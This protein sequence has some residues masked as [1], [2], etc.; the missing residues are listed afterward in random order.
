MQKLK[1]KQNAVDLYDWVLDENLK[2]FFEKCAW[3]EIYNHTNGFFDIN[4]YK[5]SQYEKTQTFELPKDLFDLDEE[6]KEEINWEI[7]FI[8]S[9]DEEE[10]KQKYWKIFENIKEIIWYLLSGFLLIALW[11][12]AYNNKQK[13]AQIEEIKQNLEIQKE[14]QKLEIEKTQV[15]P[16][17]DK[18]DIISETI[19]SIEKNID[20]E[21]RKKEKLR[22]QK[23]EINQNI[24]DI[25]LK[26]KT[27]KEKQYQLFLQKV[28]ITNK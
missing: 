24:E 9:S 23:K 27:L 13:E 17:K 22:V 2:I 28:N 15:L 3:K 18:L 5:V 21:L 4:K 25:D 26:I 12:Y 6:Q 14:K 19:E 10:N 11:F 8:I 7:P 1:L 16:I 20:D